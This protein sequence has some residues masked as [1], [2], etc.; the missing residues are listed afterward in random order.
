MKLGIYFGSFD[1]IH[2]GHMHLAKEIHQELNLDKVIILPL[3]DAPHKASIA[4]DSMKRLE[5]IS[6]ACSKFDYLEASPLIIKNHITGYS[7]D[8]ID[9]IKKKYPKASLYY[10]LGSDV[11]LNILKWKDFHTLMSNVIFTVFIRKLED[12]D[13]TS[14]IALKIKQLGG[15]V[16]LSKTPPLNISSSEIKHLISKSEDCT[17]LLPIAIHSKVLEYY[18]PRSS[19]I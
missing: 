10:L 14:T 8:M 7:Y 1:P 16:Y 9:I 2:K 5:L 13:K 17:E 4:L 18:L 19:Q 3:I 11:F 12:K 15:C 6:Q